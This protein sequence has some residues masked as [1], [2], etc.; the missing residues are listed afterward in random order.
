MEL[1][2]RGPLERETRYLQFTFQRPGD[3]NY[4][5]HFLPNAVH[6]RFYP[7]GTPLLLPEN[8]ILQFQLSLS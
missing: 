6:Q 8:K 7:D 3:L 4:I 5:P 1:V 2:Q